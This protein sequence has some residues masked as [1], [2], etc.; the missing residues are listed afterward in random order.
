MLSE[1]SVEVA[2]VAKRRTVH[3]PIIDQGKPC[4]SDAYSGTDFELLW[5][6][7]V[8]L[9]EARAQTSEPHQESEAGLYRGE[10][11]HVKRESPTSPMISAM[12]ED[13]PHPVITEGGKYFR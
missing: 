8:G 9:H 5:K 11:P 12:H 6:A 13:H 4:V 10:F 1:L 3:W 7:C 2:S